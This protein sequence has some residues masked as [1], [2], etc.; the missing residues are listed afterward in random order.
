MVVSRTNWDNQCGELQLEQIGPQPS[1]GLVFTKAPSFT[2]NVDIDAT[3]SKPCVAASM[4]LRINLG[5]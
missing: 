4:V 2:M 3:N 1:G 5:L